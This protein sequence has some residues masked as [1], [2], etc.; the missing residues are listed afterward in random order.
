MLVSELI[1]VKGPEVVSVFGRVRLQQA[2]QIMQERSVGA[3]IVVT[4]A[5]GFEGVIA[6]REV[7]EALAR[8]G[9]AALDFQVA[10]LVS[11]D[12][13]IL[14]PSDT[15]RHAMMVM[16]ERRVRHLAVVSMGAVV[17]LVSIGDVVKARLSEISPKTSPW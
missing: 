15:L 17:G 14:A 13:P 9:A 12:R 16:T 1:S 2:V 6:E 5:G 10:D 3:L 8:R 4:P 7:V 11:P